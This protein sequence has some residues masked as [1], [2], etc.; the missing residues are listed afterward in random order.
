[1]NQK[2][3]PITFAGGTFT[4]RTLLTGAAALGL[5]TLVAACSPFSKSTGGTAGSKAL[6]GADDLRDIFR[7]TAHQTTTPGA[8][9]L[10]RTPDGSLATTYGAGST[11]GSPSM[12]LADHF[13]VGSVTKTFTGTVILQL[14][15]EGKLRIEDPVARYRDDVPNGSNITLTQL[16]N[17]RSGL[18]NYSDSLE[19]NQALDDE[20]GRVW[21]PDQLLALAFR[22]PPYFAPGQG[23]HYSNTNTVLLGL[24]AEDIDRRPLGTSFQKRLFD[25]V[26]MRN[27]SFPATTSTTIPSPHPEGYMYSTNVATMK[28]AELPADQQ[29]A[30][31]AGTLKPR[32]VTH[33]NP[34]WTWSAGG[35]I[36]TAG[37]LSRWVTALGDGSLLDPSWQ[38]RRMESLQSTDPA[39]PDTRYGLGIAQFGP[40]YGHTGQLPGFQTFAGYDPAK[41]RSLVVIANLNTA[42][43]GRSVAETIAHA[44]LTKIY[45]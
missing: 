22:Y 21:T 9:L 30:A 18:F 19:L 35:A 11:S 7:Q 27:T 44:L 29:A 24:I 2:P 12:T 33:N 26:G 1:M 39:V 38:K 25:P 15:Q 31:A 40:M 13:R 45:G 43:D 20:P 28:S 3:S 14:A 6:P 41:R 16:L 10:Y 17:M 23:Y 32:D 37:D 4:R 36:S 34:S 5:G 8:V 42:P